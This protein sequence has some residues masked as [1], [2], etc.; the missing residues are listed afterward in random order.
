MLVG[1]QHGQGLNGFRHA[2]LLAQ[3]G[4]KYLDSAPDQRCRCGGST[5]VD[6]LERGQISGGAV[7][8]CLNQPRHHGGHEHQ[9]SDAVLRDGCKHGGWIEPVLNDVAC[10]AQKAWKQVHA[11]SVG[12]WPDV[13]HGILMRQ[14]V[15]H[16][17]KVGVEACQKALLGVD[18]A[19]GLTGGARGV[20]N[21]CNVLRADFNGGRRFA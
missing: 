7:L 9:V 18:H 12:Q 15:F 8:Q 20:G 10:T 21:P 19:L 14:A 6:A 4:P 2:V 11:C 1:V 5:V 16:G 17:Q 13:E 3:D